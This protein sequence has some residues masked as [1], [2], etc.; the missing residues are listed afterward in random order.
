M[1]GLGHLGGISANKLAMR[2]WSERTNPKHMGV[3]ENWDPHP[4]FCRWR[5]VH[6]LTCPTL[7]SA[8]LS[9]RR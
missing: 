8:K 5:L 1:V 9:L 7:V 3:D 6:P 2:P 4:T